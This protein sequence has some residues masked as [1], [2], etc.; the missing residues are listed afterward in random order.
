MDPSKPVSRCRH[1]ST[2]GHSFSDYLC[3][4]MAFGVDM[5]LRRTASHV[6]R[7]AVFVTA[8][9]S[10]DTAGLS[11]LRPIVQRFSTAFLVTYIFWPSIL[12][13]CLTALGVMTRDFRTSGPLWWCVWSL[14]LDTALLMDP[15]C[16]DRPACTCAGSFWWCVMYGPVIILSKAEISTQP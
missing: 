12:Y 15:L 5:W 2:S 6:G 4:P 1:D 7:S 16:S 14:W 13:G 9:G 8:P 10:L 3:P 11:L